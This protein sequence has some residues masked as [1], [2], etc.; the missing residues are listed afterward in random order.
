MSV[1]WPVPASTRTCGPSAPTRPIEAIG[2]EFIAA[3]REFYEPL[4]YLERAQVTA[5]L[6]SV[7]DLQPRLKAVDRCA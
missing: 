4:A 5:Q 2:G 6:A 7:R 1:L 3:F